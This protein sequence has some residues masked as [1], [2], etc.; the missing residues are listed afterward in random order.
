MAGF[1]NKLLNR[2]GE[3]KQSASDGANKW[4]GLKEVE[5]QGAKAQEAQTD[6]VLEK[7]K[8][9][10]VAAFVYNGGSLFDKSGASNLPKPTEEDK[11]GFMEFAQSGQLTRE[12]VQKFLGKIATQDKR[13][14]YWDAMKALGVK[15]AP[16]QTSERERNAEKLVRSGSAFQMSKT[17]VRNGQFAELGEK[18][19]DDGTCQDTILTMPKE[20]LYGVFDGMGGIAGG[21]GASQLAAGEV[22]R[23]AMS[24]RGGAGARKMMDYLNMASMVVANRM[25]GGRAGTAPGTTGVIAQIHETDR[26]KEVSWASIGD[27]RLYLIRANGEAYQVTKDDSIDGTVLS[28]VMGNYGNGARCP[29][30]NDH[31]GSFVVKTGDR[32]VLCSDGITGDKGESAMELD[33]LADIVRQAER[34]EDVAQNLAYCARKTDDRSAVCFEVR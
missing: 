20:G 4:G 18:M 28:R 14:E 29:D 2:G 22:K 31:R 23:Q 27:S 3:A 19:P 6:P 26:G 7:H 13:E 11:Q 12:D 32:V 24:E 1:F 9:K 33:E 21:R 8:D 34:V 16:E 5:F 25:P 10:V 30:D 17:Q 15:L